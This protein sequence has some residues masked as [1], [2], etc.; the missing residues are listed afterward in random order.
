MIISKNLKVL[1]LFICISLMSGCVP[2]KG[3]M[4]VV[5]APPDLLSVRKVT[6][7]VKNG[8]EATSSEE[9]AVQDAII[10]KL[11]ATGRFNQIEATGKDSKSKTGNGLLVEV[12]IIGI[13]RVDRGMRTSTAAFAGRGWIQLLVRLIDD[14]SRQVLGEAMIEGFSSSGS[15]FAGTTEDAIREAAAKVVEF[16][17]GGG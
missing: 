14:N 7:V 10:Q 15:I 2:G 3:W 5:K 17:V 1:S 16:V 12:K 9:G 4:S 11:N 8:G 6:V 13:K